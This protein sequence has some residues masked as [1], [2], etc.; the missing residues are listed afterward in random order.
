MANYRSQ[1]IQFVDTSA[2]FTERVAI[3]NVKLIAAGATATITIK[4]DNS[5]GSVI[6]EASTAANTANYDHGID[7]E[8]RGGYSVAVSGAGAKAYLY[9]E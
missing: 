1:N 6:Y 4:A 2:D 5:S 7:V 9:L 8:L 3:C